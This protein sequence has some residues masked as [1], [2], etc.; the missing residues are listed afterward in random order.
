MGAYRGGF[1]IVLPPFL[2]S[3][4]K[5]EMDNGQELGEEGKQGLE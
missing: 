5:N 2:S 3:K 4:Q 1:L